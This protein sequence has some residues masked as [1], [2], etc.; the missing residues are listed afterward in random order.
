MGHLRRDASGLRPWDRLA[1][2]RRPAQP[3][4]DKHSGSLGIGL[5]PG[6]VFGSA[7]WGEMESNL[8]N[9]R[10]HPLSQRRPSGPLIRS[11][12]TPTVCN[13]AIIRALW[14]S[15]HTLRNSVLKKL[16]QSPGSTSGT[17]QLTG[18]SFEAAGREVSGYSIIPFGFSG[19]I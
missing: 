17:R 4:T 14:N 16:C 2:D 11:L 19:G 9:V 3:L 1:L 12:Q 5:L 13:V 8:T 10:S 15:V 6:Q 7:N 18:Y